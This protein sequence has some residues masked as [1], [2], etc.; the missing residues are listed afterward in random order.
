MIDADWVDPAMG[1]WKVLDG[2]E[3]REERAGGTLLSESSTFWVLTFL[4]IMMH[5]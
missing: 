4:G 3:R 1:G 5:I 2:G